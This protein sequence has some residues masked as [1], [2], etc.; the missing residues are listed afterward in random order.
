MYGKMQASRLTEFIPF[1]FTS[2]IWGQTCF[3]V[4]L[5]GWQ[6]T[7]LA[8]PQALSSHSGVGGT[9]SW[10]TVWGALV[11]IWRPEIA[12]GCDISCLWIW[13]G[14]FYFHGMKLFLIRS[15]TWSSL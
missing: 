3:L 8:F 5:Q 1:I 7:A 6:I 11:H 15:Q 14:T 12:D 2:A 9:I 10:I 4:P 13:Q